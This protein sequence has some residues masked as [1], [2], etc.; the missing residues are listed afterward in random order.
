MSWY[1]SICDLNH[2]KGKHITSFSLFSHK[3][4]AVLRYRV[5]VQMCCGTS[6]RAWQPRGYTRTYTH[7]RTHRP[8]HVTTGCSGPGR[9][10][11]IQ[12]IQTLWSPWSGK[13]PGSEEFVHANTS[14]FLWQN[15]TTCPSLKDPHS[16]GLKWPHYSPPGSFLLSGAF[17]VSYC[18]QNMN[19][20]VTQTLSFPI[21]SVEEKIKQ[22]PGL[23]RCYINVVCEAVFS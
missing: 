3:G 15:T 4:L 12:P 7:A 20:T 16:A 1:F 19:R 13:G 22:V 6:S 21:W 18:S 9:P 10:G 8:I 17:L 11:W 5:C 23:M 14:H 2:F